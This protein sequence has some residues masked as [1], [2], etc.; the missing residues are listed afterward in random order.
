MRQQVSRFVITMLLLV[1]VISTF[2]DKTPD[3]YYAATSYTNAKEFYDS[4]G[5]ISKSHSEVYNA[6]FYLATR[7][8]SATSSTQLKFRT[9]GYDVSMT[10][11]GV[12]LSFS[13]VR[14]ESMANIHTTYGYV[15]GVKHEYNLYCIPTKT[16]IDLAKLSNPDVA[17]KVLSAS[18]INIKMDAIMTTVLGS[19]VDGKIREDGYG[20][21]IIDP[22]ASKVYHLNNANEFDYMESTFGGRGSGALNS[23][24]DIY[25][26]INNYQLTLRYNINGTPESNMGCSSTATVE[27]LGGGYS[28]N[29]TNNT[30]MQN[31][32]V[33]MQRNGV[34]QAF[35]L[36]K[37]SEIRILKKGYHI[38]PGEEWINGKT[39][40]PHSALAVVYPKDFSSVIG[41]KADTVTL[42]ANWQPNVYR[43]RYSSAGG[44]G[45][46]NTT[47]HS[48]D[49]KG[50]LANNTFSRNGYTLKTGEEWIDADGNTYANGQEVLNW[51]DEHNAEIVL[52]ANWQPSVVHIT[53]DKQG[54][55]GGSDGFWQKY[56][57]AYFSTD[58]CSSIID[59]IDTP[60]RIGYDF[61]GYYT[62]INGSGHPVVSP[63][64]ILKY[65]IGSKEPYTY[66]LRDYIIYAQWL[67]KEFKVNFDQQGGIGGTEYAIATYDKLF[68]AADAPEKEGYSFM[69]YY[70]EENGNGEQIYSSFM[71]TDKKYTYLGDVTL[72]AY[73]ID[74]TAPNVSL[75]VDI[76]GWTNQEVTLTVKAYDYGEGLSD[77]KLYRVH[78]DGTESLIKA[79]D[80]LNGK[81]EETLKYVN[82]S[83]GVIRY[84]AVATDREG[85]TAESYNTVYYD[86]TAP[87]G[88]NIVFEKDGNIFNIELDVTDINPG[89]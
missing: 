49:Q 88:S 37:P 38:N 2:I 45:T 59:K 81:V 46:V 78:E 76:A 42:Y 18:E 21:L 14:G 73:W 71:A 23:Y 31:G 60:E 79:S 66:F 77:V 54:G 83:E 61:N 69:G 57:I 89:E 33:V 70:T 74:D 52:Y 84:K 12:T 25:G 30:L 17:D 13:V 87:T 36:L 8:G 11:N 9:L 72:Y 27:D 53:A 34:M 65:A 39:N 80:G 68:P 5:K 50:N 47:V 43:I 58:D 4:T 3:D 48:Y 51:T 85:N 44:S 16:L 15:N 35:Y 56:G 26:A 64:G 86:I 82:T 29:S 28:Y 20:G 55:S 40:M 24:K 22:L 10:G 6:Q 67:E 19:R 63:L 75:S 7:G 41:I 1:V 32:S 62:G